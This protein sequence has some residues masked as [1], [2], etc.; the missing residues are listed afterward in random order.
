[1]LKHILQNNEKYCLDILGKHLYF[2]NN[3]NINKSYIL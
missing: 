3:E 1:M 2:N